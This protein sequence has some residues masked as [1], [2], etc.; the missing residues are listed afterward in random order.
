[1]Q[2][3]NTLSFDTRLQKFQNFKAKSDLH[4]TLS[5]PP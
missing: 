4:S 1:M 5:V 2:I 3:P